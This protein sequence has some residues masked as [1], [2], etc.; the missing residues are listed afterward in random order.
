MK[1]KTY[2]GWIPVLTGRLSF[3]FFGDS[4]RPKR[5]VAGYP[6]DPEAQVFVCFQERICKDGVAPEFLY[7]L[8]NKTYLRLVFLTLAKVEN[9]VL[10]GYVYISPKDK[11][12]NLKTWNEINPRFLDSKTGLIQRIQEINKNQVDDWW[13]NNIENDINPILRKEAIYG[14]TFTLN[15]NGTIELQPDDT[16]CN[17]KIPK[18]KLD[19]EDSEDNGINRDA[20]GQIFIFLKD[21]LHNHQHHAEDD[22]QITLLYPPPHSDLSQNHWIGETAKSLLRHIVRV[23]RARTL[24]FCWA[25]LGFMAYLESFLTIYKKELNQLNQENSNENLV[26]FHGLEP[27]R[28]S[29]E[30]KMTELRSKME[31]RRTLITHLVTPFIAAIGVILGGISLYRFSLPIDEPIILDPKMTNFSKSI[32]KNVVLYLGIVA[33]IFSSLYWWTLGCDGVGFSSNSKL[34][35]LAFNVTRISAFSENRWIMALFGLVGSFFFGSLAALV[36]FYWM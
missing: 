6:D 28:N 9:N 35:K 33:F 32:G 29:I 7:K 1:E 17:A 4:S 10:T 8:A 13:R 14:S 22:D 15:R 5:A 20:L 24:N 11:I 18:L 23:K 31:N 30:A 12:G 3:C 2:R 26:G 25:S 34:K 36:Y 21:I 27:L 19:G 16:G